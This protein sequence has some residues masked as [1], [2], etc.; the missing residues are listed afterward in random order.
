MS[1]IVKPAAKPTIAKVGKRPKKSY[2]TSEAE[3]KQAFMMT[4]LN[5]SWQL[6]IV[7]LVPI[8]GGYKLD[9]HFNT[10][11]LITIIGLVVASL[12][13]ALVVWN[14]LQHLPPTSEVDTHKDGAE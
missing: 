4:T 8:I 10:L 7:V 11:P 12:G 14:Q 13:M 6:A 9:E 2:M 1:T 5:M 3:A